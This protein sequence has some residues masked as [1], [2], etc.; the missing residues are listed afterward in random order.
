MIYLVLFTFVVYFVI[1]LFLSTFGNAMSVSLAIITKDGLTL[2]FEFFSYILKFSVIF[3]NKYLSE[4]CMLFICVVVVWILLTYSG[5][6]ERCDALF[7]IALF[8]N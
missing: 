3:S 6:E 5:I 1:L 2:K 8:L 7:L 4:L